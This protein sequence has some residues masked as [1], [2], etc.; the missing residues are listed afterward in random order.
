LP[1]LL[2]LQI[3]GYP[4]RDWTTIGELAE[5]LPAQHRRVTSLGPVVRRLI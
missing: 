1:Y 4:E 2:L 3:K 5:R